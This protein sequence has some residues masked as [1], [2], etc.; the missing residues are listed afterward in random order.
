MGQNNRTHLQPTKNLDLDRYLLKSVAQVIDVVCTLCCPRKILSVTDAGVQSPDVEI[1]PHQGPASSR[2]QRPL[3]QPELQPLLHDNPSGDWTLKPYCYLSFRSMHNQIGQP[4]PQL[5]EVRERYQSIAPRRMQHH[6][7]THKRITHSLTHSLP[8]QSC[9]IHV[10]A[11][12]Q[13]QQH[14]IHCLRYPQTQPEKTSQQ[15]PRVRVIPSASSS[16]L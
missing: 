10:Q 5:P 4:L 3:P 6:K 9:T 14:R 15:S 13:Q 2:I 11:S 16:P 1:L 8:V 12:P 7:V